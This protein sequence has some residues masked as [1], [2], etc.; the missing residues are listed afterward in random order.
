[1]CPLSGPFVRFWHPFDCRPLLPPWMTSSSMDD[2]AEPVSVA[3]VHRASSINVPG[4]RPTRTSY[5]LQDQYGVGR[6]EYEV[7]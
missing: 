2:F 1:M 4:R 6:T 7:P 3:L 5:L